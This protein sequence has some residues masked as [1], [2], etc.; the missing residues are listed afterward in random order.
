MSFI[1]FRVN[2]SHV[3]TFTRS[4]IAIYELNAIRLFD[5][6]SKGTT[7]RNE[8]AGNHK[9]QDQTKT[10]VLR[11]LCTAHGRVVVVVISKKGFPRVYLQ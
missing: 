2:Y 1:C 6:S 11:H 5:V 9:T 4:I 8:Q 10:F 3:E 7:S